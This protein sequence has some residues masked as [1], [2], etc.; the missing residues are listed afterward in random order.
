M[1]FVVTDVQ[2]EQAA[3]TPTSLAMGATN[4]G[5]E[6]WTLGVADFV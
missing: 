3:Y 1:G 5:H 4:L 2:T 6:A